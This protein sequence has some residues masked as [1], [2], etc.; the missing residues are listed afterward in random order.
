MQNYQLMFLHETWEI[1]FLYH[2]N[3]EIID[4]NRESSY[5]IREQRLQKQVLKHENH[6]SIVKI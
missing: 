4:D 1:L 6:T 5:P 2:S 3:P